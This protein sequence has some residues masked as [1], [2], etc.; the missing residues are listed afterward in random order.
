M[1]SEHHISG[2]IG[3]ASHLKLKN[4]VTPYKAIALVSVI[5]A[6]HVLSMAFV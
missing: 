1:L 4:Q 2:Y 5:Y 6:I 3:I